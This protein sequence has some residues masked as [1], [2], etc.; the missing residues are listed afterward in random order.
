MMST[1]QNN[2]NNLSKREKRALLLITGF[3]RENT[4]NWK[5]LV[6]PNVIINII[7]VWYYI[8]DLLLL[9]YEMDN[10]YDKWDSNALGT[11]MII[12][13]NEYILKR[14]PGGMDPFTFGIKSISTGIT[15]WRFILLKGRIYW[16]GIADASKVRS[17]LS[18]SRVYAGICSYFFY[19]DGRVYIVP[20]LSICNPTGHYI[21]R[22]SKDKNLQVDMFLS[23]YKNYYLYRTLA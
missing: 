13:Q 3:V 12:I 17:G 14:N 16:I 11:S 1:L 8:K 5:Y 4:Y 18:G 20:V 19:S 7:F 22:L 15:I 2:I 21:Q 23:N 10:K 6:I 9:A